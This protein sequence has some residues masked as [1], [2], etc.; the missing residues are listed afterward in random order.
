MNWT[1]NIMLKLNFRTLVNLMEWFFLKWLFEYKNLIENW[2]ILTVISIPKFDRR[3]AIYVFKVYPKPR[4]CDV[5]LYVTMKTM[6]FILTE[7]SVHSSRSLVAFVCRTAE[8]LCIVF[9]KI[10]QNLYM[11]FLYIKNIP[12]SIWYIDLK[13][14][15]LW[16]LI[17]FA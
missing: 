13:K 15:F 6:W 12:K 7:I 2:D 8:S 16:K 17:G 5:I 4:L 14:L 10:N 11:V 9:K 3:N 1:F